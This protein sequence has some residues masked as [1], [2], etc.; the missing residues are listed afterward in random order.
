MVPATRNDPLLYSAWL[1]CSV[2]AMESVRQFLFGPLGRSIVL[3]MH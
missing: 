3:T 2:A 1:Y